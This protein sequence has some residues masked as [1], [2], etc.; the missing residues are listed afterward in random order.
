[1][2][3]EELKSFYL[4]LIKGL[5]NGLVP[6]PDYSEH[7]SKARENNTLESSLDELDDL[8][9]KMNQGIDVS[10]F[11]K[12]AFNSLSDIREIIDNDPLF[13]RNSGN[14]EF[15]KY[16]NEV[17]EQF[18]IAGE[19]LTNEQVLKNC[20]EVLSDN[21]ALLQD[22]NKKRTAIKSDSSLSMLDK[23]IM[24][25]EANALYEKRLQARD[26]AIKVR[27]EQKVKFEA[28]LNDMKKNLNINEFINGILKSVNK[29]DVSY[30]NL[31]ISSGA[32][33]KLGDAI[34]DLR[35][36]VVVFRNDALFDEAKYN[37]ILKNCGL[38]KA[39]ESKEE[40]DKKISEIKDA[41]AKLDG[42]VELISEEVKNNTQEK[43]EEPGFSV[44][45]LIP[46]EISLDDVNEKKE[47]VSE[48]KV[49]E[50]PVVEAEK[51]SKSIETVAELVAELKKLNPNAKIS[52]ID[53]TYTLEEDI[54]TITLP[55]DFKYDNNLGINNKID[56]FTPY[57]S[58]DVK[59]PVIEEKQEET[60][61]AEP[62]A[63]E[64]RENPKKIDTAPQ[65]PSGKLKVK[66]IR[67]AVV[68][69]YVKSI[70]CFG[71]IEGICWILAG[72]NPLALTSAIAGSVTLGVLAQ[73][74]YNKLVS[75]G[76]V[77][78][79]YNE[80]ERNDPNFEGEVWVY[81]VLNKFMNMFKD[82][83]HNKKNTKEE[84]KGAS[85]EEKPKEPEVKN[86][87]VVEELTPAVEEPNKEDDIG[88]QQ[89][90][91]NTLE[92]N[93]KEIDEENTLGGRR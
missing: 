70:L 14:E 73:G 91:N 92:S 78:G 51:E 24:Y 55:K 93:L 76:T 22:A 7:Y 23:S 12:E 44:D 83:R 53:G 50:K 43:D 31:A 89:L 74:I 47:E 52:N 19:A 38:M 49:E 61:V 58:L 48:E 1:M 20:E 30:R 59:A 11:T 40:L 60:K 88:F 86:E 34:R 13:L 57:I 46:E 67:K 16:L 21:E 54:N 3:N 5:E 35:D 37:E 66:K 77:K 32:L 84:V 18:N 10:G 27:D 17:R 68:A 87:E 25:A 90:F 71:S 36:K 9:K 33:E 8:S 69:P 63:P 62:V 15:T 45:D 39:E 42:N 4:D 79:M 6:N 26:L 82:I 41:I 64:K 85:E 29:L 65:V 75:A 81:P 80:M 2:T 28:S 72:S 56:D